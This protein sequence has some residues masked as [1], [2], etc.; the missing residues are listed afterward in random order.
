[1]SDHSYRFALQMLAAVFAALWGLLG[2]EP[3]S[4]A[5][6]SCPI[7][8]G[9]ASSLR[10]AAAEIVALHERTT[11]GASASVGVTYGASS[12]LAA[13]IRAGAPIDVLLSADAE[14]V[15]A[16]ARRG[17]LVPGSEQIFASNRLV[18]VSRASPA[19]GRRA[20]AAQVLRE[21]TGRIALPAPAVPLGRYAREWLR[22]QGLLD[23]L[24]GRLVQTEHARATLAAFANESVALAIVYSSDTRGLRSGEIISEIAAE[25]QPPI[26]YSAARVARSVTPACRAAADLFIETLASARAKGVLR[27]HGFAAGPS[28]SA[29]R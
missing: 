14:I 7:L 10:D 15:T 20:S 1:M 21:S 8:V 19:T 17:A 29:L 12:A 2:P 26:R 4:A 3:V 25:R 22:A 11:A 23:V 24:D 13:Q 9:A 18:V 5:V 16:L 28:E 6:R 27:A